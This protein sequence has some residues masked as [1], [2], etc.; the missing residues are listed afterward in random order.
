MLRV[1]AS[2][3]PNI[4]ESGFV[5]DENNAQLS[6]GAHVD[7]KLKKPFVL[8]EEKL[9]KIH[10]IIK[11]QLSDKINDKY[12]FRVYR[13]DAYYYE[14]NLLE[15]VIQ[16]TGEDWKQMTALIIRL[17]DDSQIS[18]YLSFSSKGANLA[19][20]GKDRNDVFVLYSGIREYLEGEIQVRQGVEKA[21]M[22]V[23]S[24]CIVLAI[25][26]LIM[27]AYF[28]Y[29]GYG[30]TEIEKKEI[31]LHSSDI[32]EKINYLIQRNVTSSS[33]KTALSEIVIAVLSIFGILFAISF[34]VNW[35]YS[36]LP[37]NELLFGKRKDY[38][39]SRK[40]RLSKLFW[41]GIIGFLITIIGGLAVALLVK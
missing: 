25:Y 1:Q 35:L 39:D 21:I 24:I 20:E 40:E 10:S 17:N 18:F 27:V 3:A 7:Y 41:I 13:G 15:E 5:M 9:R 16:E 12:V 30:N 2:C 36:H 14:T 38:F 8:D 32:V 6:C 23:V 26:G 34:L 19:I 37:R 28:K 29:S 33:S 4:N 22:V 31:A 11:R